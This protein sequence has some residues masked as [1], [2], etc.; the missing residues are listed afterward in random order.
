M[1]GAK[2]N[3]S[4]RNIFKKL[5]ILSLS[6]EYTISL[7]NFIVSSQEYF[8]T[9][10]WIHSVN[11]RLDFWGLLDTWTSREHNVSETGFVSVL[12]K[13]VGD[14]MIYP[15]ERTILNRLFL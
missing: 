15:L 3:V 2:S 11:T 8:Q 1:L 10:P 13:G 7:V 12:D 6:Y 9:N 14:T 4:C 5:K